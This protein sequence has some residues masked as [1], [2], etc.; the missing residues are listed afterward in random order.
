MD[1]KMYVNPVS[2]YLILYFQLPIC[3][4][5]TT[6]PVSIYTSYLHNMLNPNNIFVTLFGNLYRYI[7]FCYPLQPSKG[8]RREAGMTMQC[9]TTCTT[10]VS[11]AGMAQVL[12]TY[13]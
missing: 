6:P 4:T 1:S 7:V 3:Q 11:I 2:N 10:V 8:F 5:N 12:N 9:Y 13:M